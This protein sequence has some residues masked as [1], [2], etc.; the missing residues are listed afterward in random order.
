[1]HLKSVQ[2]FGF[3][4]FPRK[5]AIRLD[6]GI[7][8]LVGPNGCGK[9]NIVDAIR[10]A[11]GEQ[12]PNML[13]CDK[14]DE[15]IFGGT[16]TR[17][18]LGLA[19]VSLTFVND[20][21]FSLDFEEVEVTRRSCRSGETEYFLNRTPCRYKDIVD[22]FLNTG[23]SSRAYSLITIDMVG[24]ILD[25]DP[26]LRRNFFEEAAGIAK[27]R[28][29]RNLTLRKLSAT[30]DDLLRVN[31]IILEIE[32]TCRS[33]KRQAGKARRYQRLRHELKE[34]ETFYLLA[35]YDELRKGRE[36]LKAQKSQLER[37]RDCRMEDLAARQEDFHKRKEEL[38]EKEEAYSALLS[39]LEKTRDEAT[40]IER[41]LAMFRE[42]KKS[43]EENL[44]RL[45]KDRTEIEKQIPCVEEQIESAHDELQQ[46][47]RTIEE[48]ETKVEQKSESLRVEEEEISSMFLKRDD[49]SNKVEKIL[50]SENDKRKVYLVLEAQREVH[51]GRIDTLSS[52]SKD[53]ENE[54]RLLSWHLCQ[55]MDQVDWF[56]KN[57]KFYEARLGELRRSMKDWKRS[58]SALAQRERELRQKALTARSELDLLKVFEERMEGHE[59]SARAILGREKRTSIRTTV[60]DCIE[61]PEEYVQAIEGALGIGLSTL[62]A[63]DETDVVSSIEFLKKNKK[64]RAV[65][66][67]LSLLK[68][69]PASGIPAGNSVIG[70]ASNFVK[71]ERTSEPVI[72]AL[73]DNF[74]L[75][76]DLRTALELFKSG[77]CPQYYLL[78]KSGEVIEPNGIIRG[79]SH[80]RQP[81]LGRK[82][83]IES[84]EKDVVALEK[85]RNNVEH[86]MLKK[87]VHL[88]KLQAEFAKL[89]EAYQEEIRKRVE[90]D[91]W[92]SS[93][94][95]AVKN[96][97]ESL[98]R[99]HKER[100]HAERELK[101]TSKRRNE[102]EE[103]IGKV[104]SLR[105]S[106]QACL[107][108]MEEDLSSKRKAIR[109]TS[110]QV[111]SERLELLRL[112]MQYDRLRD[113]LAREESSV[114][115]LREELK[116][117][118][119]EK[120]Q[121]AVETENTGSLLAE[122]ENLNAAMNV[123]KDL[124]QSEISTLESRKREQ[125]KRIEESEKEAELIS[126]ELKDHQEK[127]QDLRINLME[128]E[129]KGENLKERA[130]EELGLDLEEAQRSERVQV[131]EEQLDTLRAKIAA[132]EPVNMLAFK[133]FEEADTRLKNLLSQ[134]ADLT[135]AKDSLKKT[136]RKMD[137]IAR[138]NFKDT[139]EKVQ[140]HFKEIFSE[141]FDGGQADLRLEGDSDPLLSEIQ[142]VASPKGKKL[143]KIDLLS[144]GE[145]AL[146]AI[147]LLFAIFLV[148]PSPFYILDEI[149]APLDDANISRFIKLLRKMSSKSQITLITHNKRT[150]EAANSLYGITM[151]E[152]GVTKVVSVRLRGEEQAESHTE[153][154]SQ[155]R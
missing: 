53:L 144:S 123:N 63:K 36:S 13:R 77:A 124:L 49:M 86:E 154:V 134:K 7:T 120:S 96:L 122:K 75:C 99:L 55:G 31:D 80:S 19:E 113:D 12:R 87:E 25:S 127:I 143:T 128:V 88:Q 27:Y 82:R 54:L 43:L 60:A 108:S 29:K 65:F 89:D 98:A 18:A 81:L 85:Y 32:R 92:V 119:E 130:S 52:E 152:P 118:E 141:V 136:L 103:E 50:A 58:G 84:L 67:P 147:S 91:S 39:R 137:Q 17:K 139:Y 138:E 125:Q 131:N 105:E 150:M 90:L 47:A 10:W 126:M 38:K 146:V 148:K 106:T 42:R 30:E 112:R 83:R 2:M 61:V 133:E 51:T 100:R 33:L 78:T 40:E 66:A 104:A 135:E 149:D 20:G 24:K 21:G 8:A 97:E 28:A 145:R 37:E 26:Q 110:S 41:D 116:R 57:L 64:G 59:R 140:G 107:T 94:K 142:I 56:S 76:K 16:Q 11:L 129:T 115:T 46:L 1:M 101:R 111:E 22:L 153:L 14:M 121:I 48:V 3:K 68:P 71:C 44:D 117:C 79:G 62:I 6:A 74:L 114:A 69:K 93:T 109:N 102:V 72:R 34:V 73:L 151:E 95:Y 5:T 23:L 132:L 155:T 4:S 9:T 15:I 45:S 35:R 70:L